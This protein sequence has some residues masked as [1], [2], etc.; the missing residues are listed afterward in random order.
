V[1]ARHRQL[2]HFIE[3]QRP[4][5]RAREDHQSVTRKHAPQP[6]S[7]TGVGSAEIVHKRLV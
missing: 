7:Q 3:P 2:N 1:G 6:R 5:A 4:H